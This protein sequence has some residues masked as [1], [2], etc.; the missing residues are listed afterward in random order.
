MNQNDLITCMNNK[1]KTKL[2]CG[3]GITDITT[4]NG[5][6]E[7]YTKWKSMLKRCYSPKY[8]IRRPTYKGCTVCSDWLTFSKFKEWYNV[9]YRVEMQLDKDILIRGNKIYSPTTCKFVPQEINTLLN[10]YDNGRGIYMQ[11]VSFRKKPQKYSAQIN[12]GNGSE[13][14]GYYNTEIEAFTSYKTEKELWI[15]HQADHY[16]SLGQIDKDIHTA[17]YNWVI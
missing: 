9:N 16:F 17:L 11:G 15:K 12:R 7:C 10:G 5:N 1:N 3:V 2:V 14:I 8:H 4:K 13:H 6:E